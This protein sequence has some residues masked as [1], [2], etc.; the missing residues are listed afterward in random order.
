MIAPTGMEPGVSEDSLE[1][2]SKEQ[3]MSEGDTEEVGDFTS[4]PVEDS[5][6]LLSGTFIG[7]L[8]FYCPSLYFKLSSWERDFLDKSFPT[9]TLPTTEVACTSKNSTDNGESS[10]GSDRNIVATPPVIPSPTLPDVSTLQPMGVI[11]ASTSQIS[12]LPENAQLL[13]SVID[14]LIPTL[15]DSV[16]PS[17]LQTYWGMEAYQGNLDSVPGGNVTGEGDGKG[18]TLAWSRG[19]G[20][21]VSPIKTRSARKRLGLASATGEQLPFPLM[22]WGRLEA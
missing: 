18:K 4:G 14:T 1:S 20:M 8:R 2:H 22:I 12:T 15:K 17:P 9:T 19:L 10:S 6:E 5:T 3:Y 11:D 7:K 13:D 21:E 16:I